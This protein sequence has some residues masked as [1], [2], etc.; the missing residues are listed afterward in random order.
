MNVVL[1]VAAPTPAVLTPSHPS[2]S[3]VLVDVRQ[4]PSIYTPIVVVFNIV[5]F[6]VFIF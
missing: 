1:A 3:V 4:Q 5:I 2:C 6:H